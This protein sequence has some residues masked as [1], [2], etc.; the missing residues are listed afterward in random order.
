MN[1]RPYLLN[2]P[3]RPAPADPLPGPSDPVPAPGRE[4]G[5]PAG[6]D[7]GLEGGHGGAGAVPGRARR[8]RPEARVEDV[9]RLP[10]VRSLGASS[11]GHS[12]DNGS[13]A[14]RGRSRTEC[15]FRFPMDFVGFFVVIGAM[16]RGRRGAGRASPS[17]AVRRDHGGHR[18]P[19]HGPESRRSPRRLARRRSPFG[20]PPGC[21]RRRSLARFSRCSPD[22][23]RHLVGRERPQHRG[24]RPRRRH[25]FAG[26][27]PSPRC[28]SLAS[29]N[30]GPRRC[31]RC[32]RRPDAGGD[33]D[34]RL[35]RVC[36][37]R[38]APVFR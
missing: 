22:A 4:R 37:W 8:R 21:G 9:G 1:A 26:S 11:W 10:M 30:A 16:C 19:G 5:A 25:G 24:R 2:L 7:A 18:V 14:H 34:A 12:P 17:R 32:H 33:D 36:Q 31:H 3:P 35:S 15:A 27:P 28:A 13:V 23:G 29:A 38:L 6:S 20:R